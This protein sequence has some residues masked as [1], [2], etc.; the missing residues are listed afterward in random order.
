MAFCAH[1]LEK[2]K[3]THWEFF[4]DLKYNAF[5]EIANMLG[6]ATTARAPQSQASGLLQKSVA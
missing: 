5:E 3:I 2:V 4:N 6:S 1:P